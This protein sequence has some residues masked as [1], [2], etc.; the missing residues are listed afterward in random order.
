[1]RH[2][3]VGLDVA[4]NGRGRLRPDVVSVRDTNQGKVALQV[5]AGVQL[6]VH[7]SCAIGKGYS[8]ALVGHKIIHIRELNSIKELWT[9]TTHS[10][11]SNT[12]TNY[13]NNVRM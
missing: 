4:P 6:A 11:M 10:F 5:A 3:D 13:H 7:C 12:I 8:D 9:F 2:L 1:M